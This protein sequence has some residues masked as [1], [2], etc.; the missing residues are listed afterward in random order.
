MFEVSELRDRE[1]IFRDRT[2]AGVR[3]A[4]LVAAH[5]RP[6]LPVVLALP[7]G[8]VPV[9]APVATMLEGELDVAVASK[10]TLPWN[11]EVGYGAVAFDGTVV[12]NEA[13]VRSV[14]LDREDVARGIA[15]TRTKVERRVR[16]LRAGR[17]PLA[18][19]GRTVLVVDD[20]IASGFTMRVVLSALRALRPGHLAVAVPTAPLRS[21][22]ELERSVDA[23]YVA[24]VRTGSSFA[25]ASAYRDW[26]DV[27]EEEARAIL[28]RAAE[29]RARFPTATS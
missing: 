12:L 14:G 18:I 25:V 16:D 19:E 27:D 4:K 8:G 26:Y 11:T 3:L 29:G 28:V 1:G 21:V 17:G 13:L 20:G 2:D 9:A 23:V 24:N 7:A 10:I 22:T 15:A 5:G 6:S